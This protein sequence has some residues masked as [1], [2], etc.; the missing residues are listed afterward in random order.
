MKTN[1]KPLIISGAERTGTTAIRDALEASG[2]FWNHGEVFNFA[3][4]PRYVTQ[5]GFLRF[6]EQLS[7]SAQNWRT[8]TEASALLESYFLYLSNR[9]KALH[10]VL[11]VKLNSWMS[12]V[13]Q[14]RYPSQIPFLLE[15]IIKEKYPVILCYRRNVANQVVS[16]MVSKHFD[17]WHNVKMS[18][19]RGSITL[20]IEHATNIA[21]QII[22]S[23]KLV[24]S[25]LS[26]YQNM[27]VVVHEE[28]KIDFGN[29]GP[30]SRFL[31]RNYRVKLDNADKRKIHLSEYDK[32]KVIK[33]YVAVRSAINRTVGRLRREYLPS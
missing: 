25:A 11:D 31:L 29:R 32:A 33:N 18:D 12:L 27:C 8:E 28:H 10:P 4:D 5:T 16:L 3:N 14:P 6:I 2:H 20:D 9:S 7:F 13:P 23:E 26:Q 30:L 21:R 15:T 24:A 22:L 17:R 1:I 19:L